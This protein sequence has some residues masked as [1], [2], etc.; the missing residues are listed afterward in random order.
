MLLRVL[1]LDVLIHVRLPLPNML[2]PLPRV[3]PRVPLGMSVVRWK[4]I[5]INTLQRNTLLASDV[6]EVLVLEVLGV[7]LVLSVPRLLGAV[8]PGD[9]CLSL[10]CVMGSVE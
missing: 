4:T 5:Q 10:G 7:P 8:S 6:L 1:P 9:S 3:L 2:L